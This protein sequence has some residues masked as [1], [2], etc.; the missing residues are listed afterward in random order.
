MLPNPY[1]ISLDVTG[2]SVPYYTTVL[3][4]GLEPVIHCLLYNHENIEI[5]VDH[6]CNIPRL[7][8]SIL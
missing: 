6:P 8:D 1:L 7:L 5:Y 3:I 2:I 4:S